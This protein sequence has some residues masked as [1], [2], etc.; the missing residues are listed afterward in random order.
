M[1]EIK[2]KWRIKKARKGDKEYR[3]YYVSV[4]FSSA[5]FLLD[6]EPF[7]DPINKVIIFKPKQQNNTHYM[8]D[9]NIVIKL[10]WRIKKTK[11]RGKEYPICYINFPSRTAVFLI[12]YE[13]V[14]DPVNKVI[15]FRPKQDSIQQNSTQNQPQSQ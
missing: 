2:L 14:L 12:D 3:L 11:K 9:G 1:V 7:L 8:I 13:P 4:P 15:V 5:M 10:R 6:S